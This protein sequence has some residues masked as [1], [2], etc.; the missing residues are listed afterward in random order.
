MPVD[1][2]DVGVGGRLV[3]KVICLFPEQGTCM[4]FQSSMNYYRRLSIHQ[5]RLVLACMCWR[6]PRM[7]KNAWGVI[8]RAHSRQGSMLRLMGIECIRNVCTSMCLEGEAV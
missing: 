4:F 2:M 7:W 5:L 6:L 1:D 8:E 3:R